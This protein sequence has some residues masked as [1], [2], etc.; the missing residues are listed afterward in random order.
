ML[1]GGHL[2]YY[3]AEALRGRPLGAR[4]QEYGFRIGLVLVFSLMVFATWNDLVHLRVV[5]YLVGLVS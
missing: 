2:L 3:A 1:D 5:Q 4:A